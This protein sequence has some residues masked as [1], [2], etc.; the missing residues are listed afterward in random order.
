MTRGS[1][2]ICAIGPSASTFPWWSTVTFL[3]MLRTN[4]MSCSTTTTVWSPA[5]LR[6]SS[7]VRSVSAWVMPAI[8]SSTSN[9]LGDCGGR[10]PRE[11]RVENPFVALQPQLAVLVDRVALE[12]RR[13]LELAPDA[14]LRDPNL[15]EP[16]EVVESAAEIDGT[17]V[18][19]GLPGDAVHEGRLAGAVGTDEAAQLALFQGERHVGER[20]EPVEADGEILHP[21][22]ERWARPLGD[23]EVGDR[24]RTIV[25]WF[26]HGNH[27]QRAHV[28]GGAGWP[29]AAAVATSL[30]G[31]GSVLPDVVVLAF[32]RAT[33]LA[34]MRAP[35]PTRPSG[36]K[37]VTATKSAPST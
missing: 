32:A 36:R 24:R 5:R 31:F 22:R 23:G 19:A 15:G 13:T 30:D 29:T 14:E 4:S 20:L 17:A 1:F 8:G 12:D 11:Q 34:L 16:G 26:L 37:S 18:G 21:K 9:T 6:N 25:W 10:E 7:A 2:W 35:R 3:A 28:G 27:G 33:S